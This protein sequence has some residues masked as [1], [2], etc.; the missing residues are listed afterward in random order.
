MYLSLGMKLYKVHK[1]LK[2]KQSDWLKKCVGFNTDKKNAA[3]CFE[4]DLFKLMNHS[5]LGKIMENLR[6]SI[7]ARLVNNGEDYK[8][9]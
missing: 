4:K 7:N 5:T 2:F 3:N 9:M 8:N 1:I 6:K